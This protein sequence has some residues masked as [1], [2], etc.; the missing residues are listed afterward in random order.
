MAGP[1]IGKTQVKNLIDHLGR[2]TMVNWI[3]K[4]VPCLNE[5]PYR[6]EAARYIHTAANLGNEPVHDLL[7]V[8]NMY[9]VYHGKEIIEKY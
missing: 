6:E 5:T 2:A 3:E 7:R 9:S 8:I 4:F 1:M